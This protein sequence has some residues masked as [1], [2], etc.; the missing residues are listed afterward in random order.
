M[1]WLDDYVHEF[2]N[3]PEQ[4]SDADMLAVMKRG[5]LSEIEQRQVLR[6]VK[7]ARESADTYVHGAAIGCWDGAA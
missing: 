7:A 1:N 6:E 3:G 4:L 5:Q 2:I